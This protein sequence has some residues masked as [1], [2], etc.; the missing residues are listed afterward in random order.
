MTNIAPIGQSTYYDAEPVDQLA[1][2]D[3]NQVITMRASALEVF[4]DFS[5]YKPL[6]IENTAS[7]LAA[8]GLMQ[9]LPGKSA[10]I[11]E[12]SEDPHMPE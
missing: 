1:R 11:R 2:P 6:V 7:A 8:R 4:T 12:E 9:A 5:E 10:R 3:E